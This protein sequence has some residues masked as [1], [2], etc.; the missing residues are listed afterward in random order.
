MVTR[1]EP[2]S[3]DA[4]FCFGLAPLIIWHTRLAESIS[5]QFTVSVNTSGRVQRADVFA[6]YSRASCRARIPGAR[7]GIMKHLYEKLKFR[8][9]WLGVKC[10]GS[11]FSRRSSSSGTRGVRLGGS[12]PRSADIRRKLFLTSCDPGSIM[13]LGDLYAPVCQQHGDLL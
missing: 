11:T 6:G 1:T 5:P 3:G 10:F 12:L 4:D 8:P 9:S 13:L 2:P 7:R